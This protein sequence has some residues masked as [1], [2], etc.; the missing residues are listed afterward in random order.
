MPHFC[1]PSTY[2]WH[3][4]PPRID[5]PSMGLTPTHEIDPPHHSVPRLLKLCVEHGLF[6]YTVSKK[7]TRY[8]LL[9]LFCAP[10]LIFDIKMAKFVT[11]FGWLLVHHPMKPW[12]FL[13]K[14]LVNFVI[15][16]VIWISKKV[17]KFATFLK[18]NWKEVISSKSFSMAGVGFEPALH[19]FG[20]LN[21]T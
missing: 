6:G 9:S 1:R 19:G 7:L 21:L 13:D 4:R 14:T 20:T 2:Q 10:W 12:L 5:P 11:F 8:N 18:C 16:H 17:T 15:F 3:N